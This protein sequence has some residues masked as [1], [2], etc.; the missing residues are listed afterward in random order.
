MIFI[1]QSK[2][3]YTFCWHP[4]LKI[5]IS[6]TLLLTANVSVTSHYNFNG[7]K[8]TYIFKSK[9]IPNKDTWNYVISMIKQFC[10]REE[11]FSNNTYCIQYSITKI[12]REKKQKFSFFVKKYVPS[13]STKCTEYSESIYTWSCRGQSLVMWISRETG[14]WKQKNFTAVNKRIKYICNKA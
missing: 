13:H 6:G 7:V 9:H 11:L 4:H 1:L 8:S 2:W 12:V 10:V 5:T 14:Y 3:F